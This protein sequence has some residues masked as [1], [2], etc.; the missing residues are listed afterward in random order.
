[1]GWV[2]PTSHDDPDNNWSY[3]TDAYD[4][5]TG[6]YAYAQDKYTGSYLILIR[7]A[8]DCDKVRMWPHTNGHDSTAWVIDVYYDGGWH[9]VYSGTLVRNQWHELSI[10]AG[11]KSVT[12]ARIYASNTSY[13]L[14]VGEFDFNEVE[15]VGR[16]FGYIIG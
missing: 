1:M 3:E 15:V 12:Q 2:N 13:S 6:T 5:N 11:T 8:I 7:A 9:N 16:S 4:D 14:Y 10:P